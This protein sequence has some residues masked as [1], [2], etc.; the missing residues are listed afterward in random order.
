MSDKTTMSLAAI[1]ITDGGAF[2]LPGHAIWKRRGEPVWMGRLGQ[3]VEDVDYDEIVLHWTDIA[4]IE[5]GV[6][7]GQ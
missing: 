6:W 5:G 2:M 7:Y 4:K 1:Q 3:P